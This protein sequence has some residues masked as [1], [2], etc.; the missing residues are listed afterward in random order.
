M[1]RKGKEDNSKNTFNSTTFSINQSNQSKYEGVKTSTR[2]EY[3]W[4]KRVKVFCDILFRKQRSLIVTLIAILFFALAAIIL[5]TLITYYINMLINEEVD[6]IYATNE[7]LP[8]RRGKVTITITISMT[9]IVIM[10]YPF[11]K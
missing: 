1:L 9:I 11:Q 5:R 3:L 4:L 10:T 2:R 8:D 7:K 6:K